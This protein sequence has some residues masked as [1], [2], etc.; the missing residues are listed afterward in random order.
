MATI[1]D[2]LNELEKRLRQLKI[3]YDIFLVGG[4]PVPPTNLKNSVDTLIQRLLEVKGYAYAQKF[5]FNTLVARYS[6]YKELWRKRVR[7]KEE[8]GILRDEKELNQLIQHNI[9][10]APA[11]EA[12]DRNYT[13]VTDDPAMQ[14]NQIREFYQYMQRAHKETSGEAFSMDFDRFFHYLQVKT[15]EIRQKFN[16]P[17]VEFEAFV[18][19]DTRK[20]KFSAKVRK[21]R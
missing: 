1:E 5:R 9:S 3:E 17:A 21:E 8:Q 10:S 19:E 15:S 14:M 20:V 12:G 18:D 7:E 13:L 11:P 16:C 4:K 6:A 2:Q